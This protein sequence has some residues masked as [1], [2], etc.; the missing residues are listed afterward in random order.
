MG[1]AQCA[2]PS[3]HIAVQDHQVLVHLS[4]DLDLTLTQLYK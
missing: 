3:Y 2:D 4:R 1:G